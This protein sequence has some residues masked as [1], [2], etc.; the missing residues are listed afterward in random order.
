[1][2]RLFSILMLLF[3]ALLLA[4]MGAPYFHPETIPF[5]PFIGLLFPVWGFL[6]VAFTI[7]SFYKR[8]I[9]M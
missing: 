4:A 1:M 7:Y 2:T 9:L 5:L 3:S 8:Y 6:T